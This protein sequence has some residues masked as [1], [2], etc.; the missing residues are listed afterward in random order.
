MNSGRVF[1]AFDKAVFPKIS[2]RDVAVDATSD[3]ASDSVKE[4]GLVTAPACRQPAYCD[5]HRMQKACMCS[6]AILLN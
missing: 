4:M 1:C 2:A 5:N 3:S 6:L